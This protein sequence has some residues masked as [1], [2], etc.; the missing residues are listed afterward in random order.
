[1]IRPDRRA[2]LIAASLLV[3]CGREARV[4]KPEPPVDCGPPRAVDRRAF[5]HAGGAAVDCGCAE[6]IDRFEQTRRVQNC[7]AQMFLARKPFRARFQ[8]QGID[9]PFVQSV[10]SDGS[11]VVMFHDESATA[12]PCE[13]PAVR[14]IEGRRVLLCRDVAAG[15]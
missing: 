10:A 4:R 13:Q 7:M 15:W 6:P 9:A 2:V 3:A 8:G 12:A 14:T 11:V 5:A 1:M